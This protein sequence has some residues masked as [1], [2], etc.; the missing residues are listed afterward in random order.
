[1]SRFTYSKTIAISPLPSLNN[2]G[3]PQRRKPAGVYVATRHICMYFS[4]AHY[5]S[6]PN[7][8]LSMNHDRQ[9]HPTVASVGHNEMRHTGLGWGYTST[10]NPSEFDPNFNLTVDNS[11]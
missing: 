3:N 10:S 6:Q 2:L 8:P 9:N 5:L 1:M 4:N 7:E 11:K